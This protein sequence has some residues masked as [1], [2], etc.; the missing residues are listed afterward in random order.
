MARG[1]V[2]PLLQ[3]DKNRSLSKFEG[4]L[5]GAENQFQDIDMEN[6][7]KSLNIQTI[8][9]YRGGYLYF[10]IIAAII[11]SVY[12][13]T[14]VLQAFKVHGRRESS[15]EANFI[16]MDQI[17]N[18]DWKA[19]MIIPKWIKGPDGEDNWFLDQRSQD[20]SFLVA[21]K[22]SQNGKPKDEIVLMT[23]NWFY[24]GDEKLV[25][26]KVSTSEDLKRVLLATECQKQW[27]HSFTAR[28]WVFDIESKIIEPLDPQD[29]TSRIQLATWSPSSDSIVFTRHNNLFLRQFSA[30]KVRQITYDGGDEIFNGIPDWVYEEEV[31][32]SNRA[33]WWS[34]DGK[35]IAFLR[36]NDSQ[37]P[38]YTIQHYFSRP[39]DKSSGSS[40]GAN[41]PQ[42]A[43]IHYPM[44]GAQNPV[45]ELSF[46]DLEDLQ[47]PSIRPLNEKIFHDMIIFEVVWVGRNIL[48]STTDRASDHLQVI[49]IDATTL[50]HTICR[51]E[52]QQDLDG[53]WVEAVQSTVYVPRDLENGRPQEG[54]IS[55]ILHNNYVH[56][57]YFSPIGTRSPIVLT[58]GEWEVIATP[59]TVDLRNNL[60][61]F[62]AT[63]KSSL[64]RHVY[65]VALAGGEISA[66]TN[67]TN[68]GY[69]SAS[70]STDAN[71]INLQYLGPLT[72]WYE[73]R[74]LHNN[75]RK[76]SYLIQEER[77]AAMALHHS[78]P[79]KSFT[80]INIDGFDLRVVERRPSNF[81]EHKP[82][83]YSVLF[84]V[85]GGPGSQA[86]NL[87]FDV[88]I[89][90]YIASSQD[91]IVVTVDGRG[92]GYMGQ[93]GRAIIRDNIGHYE[94]S[95]Q[96][97]VAK[98]WAQKTYV[99]AE[100][101]TIFGWSY[102]GY[103][104][105]KTLEKDAGHTF[106]HGIAVAPVTDW[107]LY[108]SVHTER[109][110]HLPENNLGGYINSAINNM[111]ALSKADRFLLLHGAADDNVHL[112]N[113]LALVDKLDLANVTNY[114]MHIF[115][116]SDH[117]I[118]FH[119]GRRILLES[120]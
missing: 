85:Y 99:N 23:T 32:S 24:V 17:V 114:D 104:T 92:T 106:K 79:T 18:E 10:K 49:L 110:M 77:L 82:N 66:I 7:K 80:T 118:T 97:E 42:N 117:A 74:S 100:R 29:S 94:S 13:A 30:S 62:T 16:T 64:E 81:S 9:V 71:Y 39:S 46:V 43:D 12:F 95:D 107:M 109:Y 120:K 25:V 56:L 93:K 22:L 98:I 84:Y 75:F 101:M 2:C 33:T 60:V 8:S 68:D 20:D 73:I 108:D 102:G 4:D 19:Q 26:E 116:D 113:T 6:G 58:T 47:S 51:E 1:L 59:P 65:S 112:Q 115:P 3:N 91:C 40:S 63:Q 87:M 50:T 54:Y 27:R 70:F 78:L 55:T 36:T 89:P 52:S 14:L 28:Y 41:Y 31:L 61:Y 34:Q 69:F 103:I 21:V 15:P 111:T 72:P 105:L 44:V 67:T 83:G 86:V 96:L 38:K 48:V 88:D 11:F 35:K 37:V 53:G 57:A 45:V 119:N 76:D 90:E 5:E